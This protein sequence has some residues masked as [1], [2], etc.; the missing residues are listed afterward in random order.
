MRN[1][2]IGYLWILFLFF[3]AGKTHSVINPFTTSFNK[4]QQEE[5]KT[6]SKITNDTGDDNSLTKRKIKKRGL[7][8]A[9]P[10]IQNGIFL[11]TVIHKTFKPAYTE[12]VYATFLYCIGLKRGP[13]LA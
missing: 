13:P 10:H 7:P 8:G 1:L 5:F 9:I 6:A 3:L 12:S 2:K 11:S 4:H